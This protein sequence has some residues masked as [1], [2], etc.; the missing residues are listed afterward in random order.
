MI[1]EIQKRHLTAHFITSVST[2]EFTPRLIPRAR[3]TAI[4]TAIPI[5]LFIFLHAPS[6]IR[7]I[8]IMYGVAE[9]IT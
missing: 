7:I 9:F 4:I 1:E 8:P 6:A 3:Q 2:N 5:I